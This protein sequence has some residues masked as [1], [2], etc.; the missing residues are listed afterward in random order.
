MSVIT[1]YGFDGSVPQDAKGIPARIVTA[2]SGYY[3]FVSD[4]GSGV[5]RLKK[6][7]FRKRRGA[8]LD[9]TVNTVNAEDRLR[10]SDDTVT[11]DALVPTTGDWVML[12][13]NPQGESRILQTLPRKSKFERVDP[14]SSG[15]RSQIL[16]ANF[17]T[18]FILMSLNQNFNVRRLERFT[19]LAKKSGAE[20]VV[21]F[22]KADLDDGTRSA[23]VDAL[24]LDVPVRRISSLTGEG[25]DEVRKY[26]LPGKTLVFFGS[27]GVG[28]STLVNALAGDELMPTFETR[29]WDDKGRHTTTE[30]ELVLL[31]NGT[32]I[33]DTPG[34]RELGMWEMSAE[35]IAAAFPDVEA[36][37]G[38]CRFSDCRHDTEPGCAVK[39]AIESG[40]LNKERWEA[41]LRLKAET[42]APVPS[43]ARNSSCHRFR[44]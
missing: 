38:K 9:L 44:K 7:P 35:E 26:A 40:D 12:D 17:D 43:K 37:F 23:E 31:E 24:E 41:Y 42:A 14:S 25:L 22:T 6:T 34:I 32:M 29:E 20:V 8:I 4:A 15:R 13:W 36:Y 21:L 18:L 10:K 16:A 33:I 5:A 2:Y 39:A 30:R 27:S 1:R 19:A 11:E 3:K 28:K